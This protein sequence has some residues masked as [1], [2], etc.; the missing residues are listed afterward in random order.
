LPPRGSEVKNATAASSTKATPKISVI[1]FAPA[2]ERDIVCERARYLIAAIGHWRE[3]M[4]DAMGFMST[5]RAL[6]IQRPEKLEQSRYRTAVTTQ[7]EAEGAPPNLSAP[8]ATLLLGRK[9]K[10]V[11]VVAAPCSTG[12]RSKRRAIPGAIRAPRAKK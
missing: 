7:A 4:R 2:F 11:C 1:F 6:L 3:L 10:C 8:L 12:D 9:K 5:C